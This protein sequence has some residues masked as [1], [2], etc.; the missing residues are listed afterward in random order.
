MKIPIPIAKH[1]FIIM[2]ITLLQILIAVGLSG[3]TIASPA[4]SY[5]QGILDHT[6]SIS[7]E[8]RNLG[9][10][11]SRI[12]KLV[13]VKFTFNPKTIPVNEKVSVDLRDARLKDVLDDLLEPL[14][15]N[16]EASGDYVI[17][18]K[19]LITASAE[20]NDSLYKLNTEMNVLI[21][22]GTVTGENSLPLPGASVIEKGTTN[23]I[24]TDADG[25]FSL[26]VQDEKSVLVFSF[27]GYTTQEV[28]V[29]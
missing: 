24:T 14:R 3:M 25:K 7:V 28:M 16:F 6:L 26:T 22:S 10:I 15:I 2:K 4:P 8:N 19:P 29:S 18:S 5:G 9:D 11:L 12:E 1:A 23:G 17:L 21:V 13:H 27:I 20:F